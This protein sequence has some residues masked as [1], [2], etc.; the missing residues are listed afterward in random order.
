MLILKEYAKIKIF[1]EH[2]PTESESLR[3]DKI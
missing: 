1:L 2:L 3:F